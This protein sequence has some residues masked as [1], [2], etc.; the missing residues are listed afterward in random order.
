MKTDLNYRSYVGQSMLTIGPRNWAN[1]ENPEEYDDIMK[2]SN[3]NAVCVWDV[4]VLGGRE[5]CVD[6]VRGELYQWGA[7]DFV[8]NPGVTR[9]TF[10]IKGSI[11]GW[12][13]AD[14]EFYTGATQS[15]IELGNYDNYWFPGRAPTRGGLI[16]NCHKA[17]GEPI[18]VLIFDATV[19]EIIGS[20][21]KLVRVPKFVWWPY[22]VAKWAFRRISGWLR[23]E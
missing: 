7:C 18:K 15:D 21:V 16:A 1:P 5:N 20:R 9:S 10:T 23:Q 6:A 14:C 4:I 22:F 19:P 13:I 2:F 3:C 17:N 11:D 8:P 12:K